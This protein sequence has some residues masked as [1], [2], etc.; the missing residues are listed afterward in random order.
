MKLVDEKINQC[1]YKLNNKSG[2][3]CGVGVFN[4]TFWFNR[5][6]DQNQVVIVKEK[7]LSKLKF[8]KDARDVVRSILLE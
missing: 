1:T 6:R 2:Y 7:V 4:R 3:S 5:T 8:L